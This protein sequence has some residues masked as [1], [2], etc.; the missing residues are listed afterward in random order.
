MGGGAIA[1]AVLAVLALPTHALAA[2]VT[3]H[4]T[5]IVDEGT[6][7]EEEVSGFVEVR[8]RGGDRND[9]RVRV[10]RRDVAVQELGSARLA[11]G[12]GCSRRAK[13]VVVCRTRSDWRDVEVHAGARDDR[14]TGRCARRGV[15]MLGGSG[16]DRLEMGGCGGWLY[17]GFG[18]DVLV[19]DEFA[20]ELRGGAGDDRL[21]G[22]GGRDLLFG[23]GNGRDRGSDLIDGG[24]GT[25]TAAWSERDYGV[26]VDLARGTAGARDEHDRLRDVEDVEGTFGDDVLAGDRRGNRLNG[27]AGGD[28]FD[29]RGGNDV[30][31]AAG[32]E[33]EAA[34]DTFRCG[35]GTDLVIEPWLGEMRG[36]ERMRDDYYLLPFE[37][38]PVWPAQID[39]RRVAVQVACEEPSCRRQV[40]ITAAGAPLGQSPMV[41][42]RETAEPVEVTLDHPARAGSV[43][44]IEVRGDE[45]REPYRFAWRAR[46]DRAHAG[47]LCAP[48]G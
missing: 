9:L 10:H 46:C 15:L 30:I 37:I 1:A 5:K 6:R 3:A 19:G 34:A 28:R 39:A 26:S 47:A 12:A 21:F 32:F 2:T 16:N 27:H 29:G 14:V 38:L 20:Q 35:G 31:V 4:P 7:L 43:V 48:P 11:A 25:D 18:D 8:D 17:G 13:R 44:T 24:A 40:T 23:E 33:S 42:V 36:C 22:R 41:E 45:P